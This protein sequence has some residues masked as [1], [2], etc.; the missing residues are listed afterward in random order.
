MRPTVV[1][2]RRAVG[3]LLLLTAAATLAFGT[4]L[5]AS[6]SSAARSAT[7]VGIAVRDDARAVAA[8]PARATEWAVGQQRGSQGNDQLVAVLLAAAVLV[9]AQARRRAARAARPSR[10]AMRGQRSGIRA[11]PAFA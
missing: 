8:V 5:T 4:P 7:A 2:P 1:R 6:A 11:P 10:A 3:A 9:L